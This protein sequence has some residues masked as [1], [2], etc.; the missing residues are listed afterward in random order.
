MI[1]VGT[2]VTVSESD[3]YPYTGTVTEVNPTGDFGRY[4]L[5]K[6]MGRANGREHWLREARLT[7]L[8]A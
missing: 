5:Y 7:V 1:T 3:G 2:V 4:P 6:V 8:G